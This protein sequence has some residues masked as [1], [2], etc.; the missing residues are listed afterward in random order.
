[1]RTQVTTIQCFELC[2]YFLG[3]EMIERS[4][5]CYKSSYTTLP[6][7][8]FARRKFFKTPPLN[9]HIAVAYHTISTLK[10]Y[11]SQHIR[12]QTT[13]LQSIKFGDSNVNY[14]HGGGTHSNTPHGSTWD[15]QVMC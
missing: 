4:G 2:G 8:I 14:G 3:M 9:L 11:F 12:V 15:F 7:F 1:M 6:F 5:C 13:H 10:K